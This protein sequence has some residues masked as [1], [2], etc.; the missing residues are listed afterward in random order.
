MTGTA[1]VTH[2]SPLPF[3]FQS[4]SSQAGPIS[5]PIVRVEDKEKPRETRVGRSVGQLADRSISIDPFRSLGEANVHSQR[6]PRKEYDFPDDV[7]SGNE[8]S[9]QKKKSPAVRASRS[10]GRKVFFIRLRRRAKKQGEPIN[11]RI[12]AAFVSTSAFVSRSFR[13]ESIC[14]NEI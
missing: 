2:Q 6:V 7:R 14:Y 12:T 1:G 8:F 9:A 10:S 13:L 4:V 11:A 5:V 3:R